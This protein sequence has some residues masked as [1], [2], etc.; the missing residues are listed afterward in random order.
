[1]VQGKG[2]WIGGE[3]LVWGQDFGWNGEFWVVGESL[4]GGTISGGGQYFGFGKVL[5]GW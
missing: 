5:D 3:I 4:V 2:F 1:M